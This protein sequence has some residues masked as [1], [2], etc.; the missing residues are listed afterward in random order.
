MEEINILK[1]KKL[2]KYN[3]SG[4]KTN[5]FGKKKDRKIDST[6]SVKVVILGEERV[7][8]TSIAKRYCLGDHFNEM[9]QITL[10]AMC[11]KKYEYLG[12]QEDQEFLIDIWDTAGQERYKSLNQAYYRGA[13]GALV[14]YNA[15]DSTDENVQRIKQ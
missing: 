13:Q 3:N 5:K 4:L 2:Q 6:T 7:G 15:T 14:V 12:A 1:N 9:E 8:K 11:F 10:D